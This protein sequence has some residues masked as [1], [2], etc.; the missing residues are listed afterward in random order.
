MLQ[1]CPVLEVLASED[2]VGQWAR[3]AGAREWALL[4]WCHL[5]HGLHTHCIRTSSKHTTVMARQAAGS[6]TVAALKALL[7]LAMHGMA[8]VKEDGAACVVKPLYWISQGLGY[9]AK[10]S[11]SAGMP[12]LMAQLLFKSRS[13]W[14]AVRA[15]F[16]SHQLDEIMYYVL[17][18]AFFARVLLVNSKGARETQELLDNN[19]MTLTVVQVVQNCCTILQVRVAVTCTVVLLVHVCMRDNGRD[20]H[21]SRC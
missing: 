19:G 8:M 5:V 11:R 9:H 20:Q 10:D 17:M 13:F 21:T 1:L 3:A 16:V 2:A 7:G 15:R 18:A 6:V 14:G 12:V 4:Q